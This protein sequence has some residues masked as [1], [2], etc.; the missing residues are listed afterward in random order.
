MLKGNTFSLE[1]SSTLLPPIAWKVI[2]PVAVTMFTS[3]LSKTN[4]TK[5]PQSPTCEKNSFIR[6]LINITTLLLLSAYTRLVSMS[7]S[8]IDPYFLWI[9]VA[10]TCKG[11]EM[12]DIGLTNSCT[13]FP[14]RHAV[15][16]VRGDDTLEDHLKDQCNKRLSAADFMEYISFICSAPDRFPDQHSCY[17]NNIVLGLS[18]LLCS[19]FLVQYA[20]SFM[21]Q[22]CQLHVNFMSGFKFVF[23]SS[24]TGMW[25]IVLF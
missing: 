17:I 23:Q 6:V 19:H 12:Y 5:S 18:G 3:A 13:P 1:M 21:S 20:V 7:I 8:S 11:D 15:Q 9:N 16:V 2:W 10:K 22:Q 24:T 14:K 4:C 25:L